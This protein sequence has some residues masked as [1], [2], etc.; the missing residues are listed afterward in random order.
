[1]KK[2]AFSGIG[3]IVFVFVF[4]IVTTLSIEYYRIFS[5]KESVETEISRALNISVDT[6]MQDIDWIQH[7]SV[8]NTDIAEAEFKIYLTEDMGL[9]N[10]NIK[11]DSD[12]NFLYQLIIDDELIQ[13]SPAKYSI[14]GNIRMQPAIIRKFFPDGYTFDVPFSQSSRNTRY[15]D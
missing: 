6:A 4:A 3:F 13:R 8:M 10:Y 1:M 5:L 7:N 2:K 9:N 15:D 12:G 14:E 11:Y